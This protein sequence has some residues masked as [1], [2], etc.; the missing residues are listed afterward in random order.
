MPYL[1]ESFVLSEA[2]SE[3]ALEY[4]GELGRGPVGPRALV[5]RQA[6]PTLGGGRSRLACLREGRGRAPGSAQF[7]GRLTRV[8]AGVGATLVLQAFEDPC[9]EIGI[10]RRLL[11][12]EP[13]KRF[14]RRGEG[15][16]EGRAF[17]TAGQ[18]TGDTPTPVAAELPLGKRRHEAGG[19]AVRSVDCEE[20][21]AHKRF[22]AP[23]ARTVAG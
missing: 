22:D 20:E 16:V 2:G 10:G 1:V 5:G 13:A 7:N 18:M 3:T 4:A 14:E 12:S 8:S 21:D 15:A 19:L 6:R 9:R 17:L 23:A 11:A